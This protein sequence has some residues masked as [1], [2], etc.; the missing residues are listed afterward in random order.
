MSNKYRWLFI[1]ISRE[2]EG[3]KDIPLLY[4]I[5]NVAKQVEVSLFLDHTP[6][7]EIGLKFKE[8]YEEEKVREYLC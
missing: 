8:D 5:R 2:D 6:L 3:F 7:K 4:P 1:P